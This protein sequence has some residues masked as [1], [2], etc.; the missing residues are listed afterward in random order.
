MTS[1]RSLVDAMGK[2]L[3]EKILSGNS[4]NDAHAGD[5]VVANA[6]LA[7]LRDGTGPLALR[8]LQA[9]DLKQVANPEKVILFLDH[10]SPSPSREP[11]NDHIMS[12]QFAQ[13]SRA[14]LCAGLIGGLGLAAGAS[15]GDDSAVFEPTRGSAH[16]YTGQ[17]TLN[18][19]AMMLLGVLTLRHIGES[20]V[21]TVER[22]IARVIAEG[23]SVAHDMKPDRN[24]PSAVSTSRVADAVIRE[25]EE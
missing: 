20:D 21:D 1:W 4:G 22:T 7:F 14:Q 12:R 17:N 18:P 13:E 24:D 2:T 23:K 9:S 5:S 10:A 8:Q 19:T 3:T 25:M 11:A 16:K 15:I 6:A